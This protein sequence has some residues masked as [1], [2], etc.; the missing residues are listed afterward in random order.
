MPP[1]LIRELRATCGA[2]QVPR[3]GPRATAAR[4]ERGAEIRCAAHARW[5][6]SILAPGTIPGLLYSHQPRQ[7]SVVSPPHPHRRGPHETTSLSQP[8]DPS[9]SARQPHRPVHVTCP[10]ARP[11]GTRAKPCCATG[12]L[13]TKRADPSHTPNQLRVHPIL[14]RRQHGLLRRWVCEE[15]RTGHRY[16]RLVRL[17]GAR[18]SRG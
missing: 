7:R 5:R 14:V 8:F 16:R 4:A 15:T 17:S 12:S 1:K 9:R 6:C 18:M 11:A 13:S 3:D 2:A 10:H